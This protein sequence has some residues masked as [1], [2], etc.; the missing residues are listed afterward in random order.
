MRKNCKTIKTIIF[1]VIALFSLYSS[2]LATSITTVREINDAQVYSIG[3]YP[4]NSG[5][6]LSWKIVAEDET[7]YYLILDS[8][9]EYMDY[10]YDSFDSEVLLKS[11][12]S[13]TNIKKYLNEVIYNNIFNDIEKKLINEIYKGEYLRLPTLKEVNDWG[14]LKEK[15]KIYVKNEIS[16]VINNINID[17]YFIDSF[18]K[19]N[20]L[21]YMQSV[22]LKKNDIKVGIIY[23]EED[24]IDESAITSSGLRPVIKINK[25]LI[26]K[27]FESLTEEY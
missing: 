14:L 16:R 24:D 4:K 5:F 6:S 9:L 13:H 18:V 7:D 12:Y 20:N 19:Y 21:P 26:K 22:I 8:V 15:N 11:P 10:N 25:Y 27:Y 17:S 1:I 23:N 3:K 2:C